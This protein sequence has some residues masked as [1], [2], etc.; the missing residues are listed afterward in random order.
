MSLPMPQTSGMAAIVGDGRRRALLGLAAVSTAVPRLVHAEP[1]VDKKRIFIVSSYS[2]DYIW[3]KSTQRGVNAGMLKY[4][5]L[6]SEAQGE[7][8]MRNDQV[9]SRRAVIR[10]EWMDTKRHNSRSEIAVSTRRIVEE[11]GRFRPDLVLL[12]D[13]NAANYIG[14]QLLGGD[15]PVVFWGVNGLPLKYGLIENLDA[16]GRNV[17][18]VWQ[19]GYHKESLELLKRLVPTAKTFAILACDSETSRPNVKMIE[20]LAKRDALPL[21]LADTIVTN[22]YEEFKRRALEASRKVDAFFVLN[23]DTLRD[24]QGRYVDMLDVGRWYLENIRIPEASHEDQFVHEG[25]L[26]TANDSGFNQG[27]MALEMANLIL[28]KRSTPARMAVRTPDRGPYLVN[29][30]RADQLR[31]SLT[32]SLFMID[33]VI[34]HSVALGRKR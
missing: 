4:G 30:I 27:Y 6:D 11:I 17:T 19:S 18:G 21:R 32:E 14:N 2:R 7:A 34:T 25:M 1:R 24:A 10:K 3:S 5:Y 9:E 15:T 20:Q 16:P 29:K 8:L 22:S 23:H 28:E 26:L 31:I 12:G 33:E 13:D